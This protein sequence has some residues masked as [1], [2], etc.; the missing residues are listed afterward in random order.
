MTPSVKGTDIDNPIDFRANLR[1]TSDSDSES[2]IPTKN[3]I[4][5]SVFLQ[6]NNLVNTTNVHQE[7]SSSADESTKYSVPFDFCDDVNSKYN[8]SL[9]YDETTSEDELFSFAVV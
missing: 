4:S 9:I 8:V 6:D 3:W 5:T 2:D 1:I 7:Q